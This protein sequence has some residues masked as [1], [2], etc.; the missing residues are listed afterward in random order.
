MK[1]PVFRTAT[2]P[3]RGPVKSVE[4]GFPWVITGRF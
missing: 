3:S 2:G 4:G 1:V